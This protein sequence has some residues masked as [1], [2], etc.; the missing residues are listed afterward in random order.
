M[1]MKLCPK[2]KQQTLEFK[3]GCYVDN[4]SRICVNPECDYEHVLEVSTYP[5]K[6]GTQEENEDPYISGFEV[7]AK[8]A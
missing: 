6:G 8:G 1:I 5:V 3:H 7:E 2:C 4:D